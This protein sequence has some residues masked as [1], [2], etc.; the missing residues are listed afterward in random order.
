NELTRHRYEVVLHKQPARALDLGAAP[1]SEWG[2]A[3]GSLDELVARVEDPVRVTGLP[4][5]RLAGES[6]EQVGSLVDPEDVVAWAAERGLSAYPTWSSE[7]PDLFD[8]VLVPA[9]LDQTVVTGSYLASAASA[10]EVVNVPFAA[11]ATDELLASV[12]AHAA[13]RLP[14]YMVP[15]ALVAIPEIPLSPNGKLDRRALPAPVTASA[16]SSGRL[17]S[18]EEVLCGLFGEVLGV[19]DVGVDDDFFLLG[20][21]SLLATRLVSRVRAVLGV[22]LP[23]RV[24][25]D[26]SSVRRLVSGLG[27]DGGV[28]TEL[29]ARERPEVVPLSFAQRRL[30]FLWRFE[31]ASA[32]YN[33]PMALRL[34][35]EVDLQALGDAVRDVVGRHEA[36]RT[37][38]PEVD[39]EPRQLVVSPEAAVVDWATL[40]VTE[41]QLPTVTGA[42]ARQP[43]D[44]DRDL[45]VRGRALTVGPGEHVLMLVTHHIAGDGWSVAPLVRDLV[46]AYTARRS[47]TAP[48]WSPLPVQYAD[49]TLWQ[50][51]L[52]GEVDDPGSLFSRQVDYWRD[53]LA[54][55]GG[56]VSLPT[57][58]PR[59]A[60]ASFLGDTVEFDLGT[61]ISGRVADVARQTGA[62][63]FMVLQASLAALL[64]RWGA[65]TDI[66]LGSGVA[67]RTDEALEDLVGFFVNTVVLRADVS[68]DPSF[69]ELVRRVRERSLGAFAHQDVPFDHLVEVLNPD[70]SPAYHPMFQVAMVLQNTPE[71]NLTVPGATVSPLSTSTGTARFDLLVS[72][73]E[74]SADGG[75]LTGFVEYATDLFD[76]TTIT[77]FL[78]RWTRVLE[79]VTGDLDLPV[80][81]LDL[82]G[83][84]ERGRVLLEWNDSG[85]DVR[86]LPLGELIGEHVDRDG[87]A[88]AVASAEV[89]L[90]YAELDARANR[91]AR[92]LGEQ[93]VGAG[94]VVGLR[95]PRSVDLVVAVLAVSRSGAAFLP[96]DPTYPRD[97]LDLMVADARPV[98][99]VD[100]AVLA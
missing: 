45:P 19:T 61:E 29:G 24:L 28:R 74:D 58:R 31:G 79:Q 47:D 38:F 51:D 88:I 71:A 11:L 4:N 18:V 10:G 93:G 41:D 15:S 23:I 54:G 94:S 97:R 70:R 25:F 100:E 16:V 26:A 43:F 60:V 1:V 9:S 2:S 89:H 98:L 95:L 76:R 67:G 50:R 7:S 65:G 37:I 8:V 48:A 96:L 82:V 64:S 14:E 49:Y 39:G 90:T 81:R 33:M 63:V 3:I 92:W 6:R 80:Q 73:T 83:D 77:G 40:D 13:G 20:G 66:P 35:G 32:T 36:L 12:R 56:V 59:P 69:R 72:L 86:H 62:T 22:E 99:V 34:S 57:D 84:V 21:H 78:A 30:W 53:Q 55:L 5:A 91:L 85:R 75:N 27:W 42:L 17:S 46:A 52:L 68:G 44:L 87:S